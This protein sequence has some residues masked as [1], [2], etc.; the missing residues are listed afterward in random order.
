M[1][2]PGFAINDLEQVEGV[3]AKVHRT[4]GRIEH[5]DGARVF[6]RSVRNENGLFE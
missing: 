4:A 2:V 3:E 6:D 1:V 5:Q